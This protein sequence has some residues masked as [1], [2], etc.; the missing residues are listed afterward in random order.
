MQGLG[1]FAKWFRVSGVWD[2]VVAYY[3]KGPRTPKK[4]VLGP[5]YYTIE[6]IWVLKS[7]YLCP[8]TLRVWHTSHTSDIIVFGRKLV[9]CSKWAPPP[10][11]PM[12]LEPLPTMPNPKGPCRYMVYT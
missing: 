5:K 4:K 1:Y 12:T 9:T 11:T 8:W 7:H 6:G 3:P 2:Y 10:K